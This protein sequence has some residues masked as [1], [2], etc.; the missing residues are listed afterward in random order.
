MATVM[1]SANV[2]ACMNVVEHAIPNANASAQ[3]KEEYE[4][5]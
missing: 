5:V 1:V 4:K 2:L 3:P